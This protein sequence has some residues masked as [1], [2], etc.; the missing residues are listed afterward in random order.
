MMSAEESTKFDAWLETKLT[1]AASAQTGLHP[2]PAQARYKAASLQPNSLMSFVLTFRSLASHR[3]AVAAAVAVVA[4]VAV[5]G[6]AEAAITGSADPGNWGQQVVRQV[7]KCQAALAPGS[8]GIG[9]CVSSFAFQHGERGSGTNA[10]N[11][12]PK[13]TP[14]PPTNQTSNPGAG[15][16]N[17]ANPGAGNSNSG[18]PGAGNSN[19]GKPGAGN[20]N[21]GNAGAGNSNSG[22]P[23]HKPDKPAHVKAPKS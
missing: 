5:G 6:G 22:N 2:L 15:N 12:D 8:H 21:S 20:S 16:S 10:A 1:Q 18:N 17:S 7:Q 3:A 9:E 23:G 14:A 4:L 13:H 11:N 19:S